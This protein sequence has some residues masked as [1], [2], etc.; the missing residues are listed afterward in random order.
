MTCTSTLGKVK[1]KSGDKWAAACSVGWTVASAFY[2]KS[3][4]FK[5]T[6]KF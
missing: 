6:C 5:T 4:R 3:E 2:R 1:S